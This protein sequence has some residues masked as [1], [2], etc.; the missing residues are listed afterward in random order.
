MNKPFRMEDA[1]RHNSEKRVAF[2]IKDA[3]RRQF[4]G[5]DWQA[6]LN[7]LTDANEFEFESETVQ[8]MIESPGPDCDCGF[9]SCQDWQ[10]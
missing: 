7:D 4:Q 3:H 10:D 5:Q 2:L 9:C 1:I 6:A 8:R